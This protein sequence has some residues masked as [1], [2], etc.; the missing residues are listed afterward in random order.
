MTN[1]A[2][3]TDS[4][5]I[6]NEFVGGS[7]TEQQY[8][9]LIGVGLLKD[10]DGV[11]FQYMGDDQQPK[12]LMLPSGRPLTRIANVRV[13]GVDIATDVG[14]FNSTKLNLILQTT[15]GSLVML[16]SGLTTMWSQSV[17]S[18][19]VGMLNQDLL[20]EFIQL[21]S[22]HGTSKL[23]PQFAAVRVK[24]QK[25]SDDEMYEFFRE[26]RTNKDNEQKT[27]LA[28]NCVNMLRQALDVEPV[29][30]EL[31]A[32]EPSTTTSEF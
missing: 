5:S 25:I 32:A 30:V 24:G 31:E 19:L 28:T 13:A 11:F 8:D 15:S 3:R 2:T 29:S 6:I 7:S 12:A 20:S 21:D 23:R 17:L 14:E 26:A 27:T 18:A 16:T 4:A 1:L 9:M 22:W 10:S